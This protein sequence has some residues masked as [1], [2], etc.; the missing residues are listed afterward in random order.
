MILNKFAKI[1]CN[2]YFSMFLHLDSSTLWWFFVVWSTPSPGWV[3][4]IVWILDPYI[5]ALNKF[6][7]PG[8]AFCKQNLT[9]MPHTNFKQMS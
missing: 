5:S 3:G 4:L 6:K 9:K 1:T 2:S 7:N 8:L